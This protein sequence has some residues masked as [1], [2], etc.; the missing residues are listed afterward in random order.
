MEDTAD[1]PAP[2]DERAA[3]EELER[4]HRGIEHYRRQRRAVADQFDQF[5]GS[6][7]KPADMQ[8]VPLERARPESPSP[9]A[10]VTIAAPAPPVPVSMETPPVPVG[11]QT[12]PPEP[13]MDALTA[14]LRGIPSD[15]W[16]APAAAAVTVAESIGEPVQEPA[17]KRTSRIVA[18]ALLVAVL[19]GVIAW[20]LWSRRAGPSQP[21]ETAATSAAPA[22]TPPATPPSPAPTPAAPEEDAAAVV[23]T[24]RAVWLRVTVDGERVLE[25]QLPA[26]TRIPLKP[27]TTILI[28]TGDAGAVR[29]TIG[30][31]DQGTLGKNGEVVTRTFAIPPKNP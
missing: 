23:F 24:T 7:P 22:T 2:F 6:F 27:R 30:G 25:R 1:R 31:K 20:S 5:V 29:L 12:P 21:V 4:L 11:T 28:R 10:P 3:L 26:D 13:T 14:R 9:A 16:T 8:L 18:L 17:P 15:A 19:A